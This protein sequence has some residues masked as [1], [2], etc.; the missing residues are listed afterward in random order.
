MILAEWLDWAKKRID[1]LDAELIAVYCF[2]PRQGVDRSWLV[3]HTEKEL[4]A[5]TKKK[6]DL[7][8][9]RRAKGK[10]LAYL[11][12]EKEF[13]GRKFRVLPGV[14]IPRPETE[15][16]IDLVKELPIGR[17]PRILEIGTGSGCIA[18]TLALEI[19]QSE[20]VAGDISHEA[21]KIATFNN[22]ALEGRV[23][24]VRSDMFSDFYFEPGTLEPEDPD[25]DP[26]L[27]ETYFDV[28]VAN[29]PYVNPKWEWLDHKSLSYEPKKALFEE[30]RN[31]LG[32]YKRLFNEIKVVRTK[33][34]VVEADPCQ[35]EELVEMAREKGWK[36]REIRGFGLSFEKVL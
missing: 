35:H 27:D 29:L 24:I 33:Y 32:M 9:E 19:P 25:Y 16:L 14:L 36:L 34:V 31:G 10:P 1:G 21:L 26:R 12:R 11:L 15:D 2:A 17:R 8:V 6:A 23:E 18:I 7:M 13:Y 30:E 3:T 5:E 28:V 4:P 22:R 20:V